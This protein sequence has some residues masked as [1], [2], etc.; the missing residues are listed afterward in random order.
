MIVV[1][2]GLAASGGGA[3]LVLPERHV[4]VPGH[5]VGQI[6]MAFG[7]AKL[8]CHEGAEQ[9][10]SDCGPAMSASC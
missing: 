7:I 6:D 10:Q 5:G 3:T 8:H 1:E 9:A 4:H 2:R